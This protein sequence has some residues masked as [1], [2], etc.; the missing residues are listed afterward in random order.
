MSRRTAAG[1]GENG[2]AVD[3]VPSAL[4]PKRP[5]LGS[6]GRQP[7]SK[8]RARALKSAA[9]ALQ[10]RSSPSMQAARR[11]RR[12]PPSSEPIEPS[13]GM[14]RGRAPAVSDR[15]WPDGTR[16]IFP[17]SAGLSTASLFSRAM[18]KRARRKLLSE[19][20][21]ANA[22]RP[23]GTL[24]SEGQRFCQ[25]EFSGRRLSR[26]SAAP[27]LALARRRAEAPRRSLYRPASQN[28]LRR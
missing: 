26:R 13:L 2:G 7:N 15:T 9:P 19:K 28:R 18:G 23:R 14:I 17:G 24:F 4:R 1:S 22:G 11:G 25:A 5:R 12:A 16:G 6:E 10:F 3:P 20:G 21:V 8:D 27:S